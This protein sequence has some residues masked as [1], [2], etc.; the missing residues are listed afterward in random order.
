M[1]TSALTMQLAHLQLTC[2]CAVTTQHC[3]HVF[4]RYI[5]GV[6]AYSVILFFLPLGRTRSITSALLLQLSQLPNQLIS[7]RI[8]Q[9]NL[10]DLPDAGPTCLFCLLERPREARMQCSLSLLKRSTTEN[11]GDGPRPPPSQPFT[12]GNKVFTCAFQLL[13]AVRFPADCARRVRTAGPSSANRSAFAF[14]SSPSS[15]RSRNP[16]ASRRLDTAPHRNERDCFKL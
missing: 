6:T 11:P 3:R 5:E 4:C 1:D 9:M 16:A 10:R 7:K 8:L 12:S 14:S 2:Q 13:P 15:P